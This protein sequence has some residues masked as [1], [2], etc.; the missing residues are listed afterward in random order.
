MNIY[1][2]TL[3]CIRHYG[4]GYKKRED[5]QTQTISAKDGD[6]AVRKAKKKVAFAEP[7]LEGL[8]R[9]IENVD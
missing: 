2:V 8:E 1:K 6:A 9:L 4:N 3:S 5:E 7:L